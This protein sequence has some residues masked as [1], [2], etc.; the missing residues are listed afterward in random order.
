[1]GNN[2]KNCIYIISQIAQIKK[3]NKIYIFKSCWRVRFAKFVAV[4]QKAVRYLK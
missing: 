3:F 2:K 1:M 4:I